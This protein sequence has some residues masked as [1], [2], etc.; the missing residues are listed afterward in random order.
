MPEDTGNTF[1]HPQEARDAVFSAKGGQKSACAGYVYRMA[2]YVK[3]GVFKDKGAGNAGETKYFN[4]LS[5]L[6]YVKTNDGSWESSS[7]TKKELIAAINN[8][9]FK[10]GTIVNYQWYNTTSNVNASRYGHTQMYLGN[11]KWESSWEYNYGSDFVYRNNTPSDSLWHFSV[12]ELNGVPGTYSIGCNTL[13]DSYYQN[14]N[15]GETPSTASADVIKK[16]VYCAKKLKS[17]LGLE[18]FQV[19][20]IVG[21][22][23]QE[24]QINPKVENGNGCYG[25]AQWCPYN[26]HGRKGDLQQKAN[27]DT[28]DVQLDF[29]KQELQ[30]NSR[31]GLSNLRNAKNYSEAADIFCDLYERPGK[32]EANKPKRRGHAK[33]ILDALHS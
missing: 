13:E 24:S 16:G 7:L 18:D 25:I 21:N 6:G 23:I 11:G 12:Y 3:N 17:T 26:G 30:G 32:G 28:L 27:Y 31:L 14:D 9:S 1:Y 29:I 33:R 4:G 5:N 10:P 20:G 2:Y 19:A 22:L 8:N 15:Y